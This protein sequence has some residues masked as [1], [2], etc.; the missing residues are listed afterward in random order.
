M[1]TQAAT[2]LKPLGDHVEISWDAKGC[3]Y[4]PKRPNLMDCDGSGVM[5]AP[6]TDALKVYGIATSTSHEERIGITDDVLYVR[7]TVYAGDNPYFLIFAFDPASCESTQKLV[8]LTLLNRLPIP[9]LR[10]W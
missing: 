2:D 10:P 7:L 6:Q 1:L 3:S 8:P 9:H 4:D 5:T